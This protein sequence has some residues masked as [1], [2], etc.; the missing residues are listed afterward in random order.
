MINENKNFFRFFDVRGSIATLQTLCIRLNYARYFNDEY[1]LDPNTFI[2]DTMSNLNFEDFKEEIKKSYFYSICKK[3][4]QKDLLRLYNMQ[5][6]AEQE[7]TKYMRLFFRYFQQDSLILCLTREVNNPQMWNNYAQKSKGMV[8][9]FQASEKRDSL[10]LNS[11]PVNYVEDPR[12]YKSLS[13]KLNDIFD[14]TNQNFGKTLRK[15]EKQ[16]EVFCYTKA[17]QWEYEKEW[18][19][20][21]PTTRLLKTP[22]LEELALSRYEQIEKGI[23]E[24][25]NK[26][27]DQQ[28]ALHKND[29][30]A[31][32]L[33]HECEILDQILFLRKVQDI[34]IPIY[35][36]I[37]SQKSLTFQKIY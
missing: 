37:F 27:K 15:L 8:I 26:I 30:K 11:R 12:L 10:F 32:Y 17:K 31:I 21:M 19:I 2:T 3:F 25:W 7:H 33:G 18:R 13:E 4:S 28:V 16:I 5:R 22:S 20:L 9:E 23:V 35:R 36:G 34:K 1:E 24:P 14:I 29:I 6:Q